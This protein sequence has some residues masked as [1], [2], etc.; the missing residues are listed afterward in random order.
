MP[1]I[2][3]YNET[4][5]NE[6]GYSCDP[7]DRGGETY[8]GI[9]RK[10]FPGWPGWPIVDKHKPLKNGE[11]IHSPELD[12]LVQSFYKEK[13]WDVNNLDIIDMTIPDLAE[14]MFDAGVNV[15][16]GKAAKWFQSSLNL[17]NRNQKS[18]PDIKVDGGIGSGSIKAM[19]SCLKTNPPKRLITV[20]A[21]YQGEFYKDIMEKDPTQE[22]Y[23]GW[24]DRV[25][26]N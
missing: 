13:F 9:T 25:S 15:G 24:F 8:K 11:I 26:Y 21:I 10:N 23:V 18:Y 22:Q 1:F 5:E 16:A 19:Q 12:T 2:N 4:M 14:K 17:L 6:G 20:F 7:N 3:A